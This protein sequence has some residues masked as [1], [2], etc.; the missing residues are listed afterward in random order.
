MNASPQLAKIRKM[1]IG[2]L[3]RDFAAFVMPEATRDNWE[4][5]AAVL[6]KK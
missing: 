4:H 5:T 6:R 1:A 3:A 2:L